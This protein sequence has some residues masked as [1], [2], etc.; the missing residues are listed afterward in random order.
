[1]L[2]RA[3]E[4]VPNGNK[5]ALKRLKKKQINYLQELADFVRSKLTRVE[6]KKLVALITMEIH[7]RDTQDKMIKADCASVNDFEWL[8]QLRYLFHKDD[9][10]HPEF[11]NT[12]VH[13]TNAQLEYS[14]E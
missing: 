11:G 3:L 7:S 10:D 2:T 12:T 6:R 5:S 9:P 4:A 14:Y 1:M 13:S 8:M